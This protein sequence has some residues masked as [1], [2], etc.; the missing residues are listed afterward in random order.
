MAS[1]LL[2]FLFGMKISKRT[3]TLTLSAVIAALYTALTLLSYFV[4]KAIGG[5]DAVMATTFAFVTMSMAEIIHSFN[6]RSRDKSVFELDS[7]NRVLWLAMLASFVLTTF[8]V[9]AMPKAFSFAENITVWEY[10]IAL[11]I[12]ALILP[13]SEGVKYLRRNK[14]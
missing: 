9:F 6:L 2:P 10:A 7:H 13:I 1:L 3:K 8:V 14:K 11:I 4:G 12:G 5:G